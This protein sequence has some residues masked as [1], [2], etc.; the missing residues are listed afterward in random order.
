M[1]SFWI[2]GSC[3]VNPIIHGL[4]PRPSRYE[5]RQC[6]PLLH[7]LFS[8]GFTL[9]LLY[10]KSLND[11]S[12]GEQ[13]ILF[14]SNLNVSLDFVSGNIEILGKQNSLFPS[15][16]VI[17][18]LLFHVKRA[19]VG[20]SPFWQTRKKPFGVIYD[21]YKMKQS[22]WLLCVAK[23]CDWSRK[24]TPLSNLTWA[25]PLLKGRF[26]RCDFDACDKLTTGLR[27]DLGPFTRARLFS[28][29]KL[30]MQTEFEPGFTERK[31]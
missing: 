24:I 26:T 2:Y 18:C 21:L 5:I 11:W 19:K 29:T 15:G 23:D 20:P 16:P 28:L 25:S 22:H 7:Y 6:W 27:H 30:N 17:K 3:V 12:L 10:N 1:C 8:T 9:F 31:F 4:A 14:P 13:W